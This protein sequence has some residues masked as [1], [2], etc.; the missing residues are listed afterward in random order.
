MSWAEGFSNMKKPNK[1]VVLGET[2]KV[3]WQKKPIVDQHGRNLAG[4]F[5]SVNRKIVV[6]LS[7]NDKFD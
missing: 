5:D 1:I 3:V 6:H 7:G 2:I 4:Y